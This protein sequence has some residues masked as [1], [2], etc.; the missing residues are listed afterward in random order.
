M[1]RPLIV[2]IASATVFWGGA[3]DVDT[4]RPPKC[5]PNGQVLNPTLDCVISDKHQLIV[6]ADVLNRYPHCPRENI[7][8][9]GA[10]EGV[11]IMC[12]EELLGTNNTI[13]DSSKL[14]GLSCSDDEISKNLFDVPPVVSIKKCCPSERKFNNYTTGCWD[15]DVKND[16][17]TVDKLLKALLNSTPSYI[18]I[19]F[20]SPD[21]K[22]N[23]M[24][25]EHQIP[26]KQVRQLD[27][28]AILMRI[29]GHNETI[30]LP[31]EIICVDMYSYDDLTLIVRFCQDEKLTCKIQRKAC[32]RKCCPDGQSLFKAINKNCNSSKYSFN[33]K[34]YSNVNNGNRKLINEIRPAITYGQNCENVY[35]LEPWKYE[36]DKT[37]LDESG[38]VYIPASKEYLN[39]DDYCI[40]FVTFTELNRSE[41]ATFL[42]FPD[43]QD[44][45]AQ[46]SNLTSS[47]F[48]AVAT[49]NI[50][51]CFFLLL[52]LFV[53]LCL[54]NLQNIHGK[55]VMC[56]IFSLLVAYVFLT[57]N[58][59]G[60]I[61]LILRE[62]NNCRAVGY[63]TMFTFLA[64]FSWLNVLCFD[65]WYTFGSARSS[66]VRKES[67]KTSCRFLLYNVYCW[68]LSALITTSIIATDYAA[69]FGL[70]SHN[71]VSDMGIVRCWFSYRTN[72]KM[73]FFIIPVGIQLFI[74]LILFILTTRHCLRVRSEV[75]KM[76]NNSSAK[77]RYNTDKKKFTMT[78]K[79]FTVMGITWVSEILS[80]FIDPASGWWLPSDVANV[81]QGILIF[82]LFV[83]K[84]TII[85]SVSHRMREI[86]PC[87]GKKETRKQKK[88]SNSST[89]FTTVSSE[90]KLSSVRQK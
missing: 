74:N 28:E 86:L 4:H 53:Y 76:H 55:T 10:T 54:P 59:L 12:L 9:V 52:T 70:V 75:S 84:R 64:A 6:P 66:F 80:Q 35:I 72:G 46:H 90:C 60:S 15:S 42:C 44:Q 87:C 82:L 77:M 13:R 18:D 24:L 56:Y 43:V 65:I 47:F 33:P 29:P 2:L 20:G 30:I 49:G 40:D 88:R 83:F 45:V 41:L 25:V 32:I 37:Y 38:E 89:I 79:L 62:E 17:K 27:N 26:Y 69:K 58:Q 61:F 81:F 16:K 73:I 68:G 36:Y 57:V 21:C 78:V 7:K 48:I 50:V 39:K 23:E 85:K 3:V 8:I 67:R 19:T 1:S 5:C 71:W 34:F 31:P 51:S 14:I 22:T 63:A 11:H